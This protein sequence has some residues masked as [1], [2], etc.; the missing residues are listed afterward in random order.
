MDSAEGEA[1]FLP[2]VVSVTSRNL[3]PDGYKP[4][5]VTVAVMARYPPLRLNG[6]R[7]GRTGW[8]LDNRSP[9]LGYQHGT[10]YTVVLPG[11]DVDNIMNTCGRSGYPA[12]L[13]S[14]YDGTLRGR[15]R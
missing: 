9:L 10:A 3:Q 7:S 13:A 4:T 6:K 11:R 5:G 2:L 8:S 1:H 14:P 15:C 12:Y